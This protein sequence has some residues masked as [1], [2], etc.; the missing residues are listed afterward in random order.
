MEVRP[1]ATRAL[2]GLSAELLRALGACDGELLSRRG[3][4]AL[5][6]AGVDH[7]EAGRPQE[8]PRRIVP[9]DA[10]RLRVLVLTALVVP[11]AGRFRDQQ[12]YLGIPV[13]AGRQA[14]RWPLR[15]DEL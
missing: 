12:L 6:L 2:S 15:S 1:T 10:L 9:H 11:L 8:D 7:D 14:R 13:V 3:A 5:D 4:H